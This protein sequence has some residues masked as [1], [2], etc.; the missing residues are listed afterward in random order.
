MRLANRRPH[1]WLTALLSL[2]CLT[3]ASQYCTSPTPDAPILIT[4]DCIDPAF[5]TP[6]IT[7]E[8]D[9][10]IPVPHHRVSGYINNTSVNFNIYLPPKS[11]YSNRFFQLVY[12]LQNSTA[13]DDAIAFGADSGAYT[14]RVAAGV[15]YRGDAAVAKFSKL[16]ANEYY[17]DKDSES[18]RI[19]GYI[20]GGSGGSLQTIGALEN[21][22]GVWDG[23]IA[24]IQAIPM[25]NPNNWSIRA[26]AGIVL[27]GKS[28]QVVDAVRPGGSGDPFAGLKDY[29]RLILEEATA[30]GIPL[31]AWE[32]FDGLARNR[33]KLYQVLRTLVVSEIQRKD[34]GYVDDF[35][36]VSGYLG[37]EDSELGSFFRRSLVEYNDTVQSVE[38]DANGVPVG[39]RLGVIPEGSPIGLEFTILSAS[40]DQDL[41][42]FTGLLN[43]DDGFVY[44]YSDNNPAILAYLA[45]GTQLQIDNRWYLAVHTWHRHQVPPVED[46]YY[47]YDYLRDVNGEPLYPQRETL[48]APSTSAGASGGGTHTGAINSK[49]FVMDN[50]ADYDA[51]PWHADWYKGRVQKALGTRFG[52]NYRLYY[53]EHA[54]HQMGAVPKAL[55]ARIVDFTGLYEWLLRDLSDWVERGVDPP[56]QSLYEVESGQVV[57]EKSAAKRGGI[58][59]LVELTVE[60]ANSTDITTGEPVVLRVRAEV[61]RGAGKIVSVEWDFEGTG[62]FVRRELK[63]A[64]K[65]I[66]IKVRHAYGTAGTYLPA[67]RVAAHKDGDT[68]TAF[69]RALNLGRVRVVVN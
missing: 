28:A 32:D 5:T 61:P 4:P 63:K 60:G 25:S 11:A 31:R 54:D 2:F 27:D 69:A 56:V 43:K 65:S 45:E 13:E 8:T 59:P 30:L 7:S 26:L 48:L 15:G 34:P 21:T 22:Q 67:V 68:E 17:G 46:G 9:V 64:S 62:D 29:E 66:D 37:V 36:S 52:D 42:S 3:F 19:Y 44:I 35:W 23:G 50:L 10:L 16:V 12:P 1:I 41:G 33:T 39:I 40:G 6:I 57:L 47:G 58:Q 55:Q 49:L 24:L 51:F 18:A 14:V 53:N 38:R 20:Y